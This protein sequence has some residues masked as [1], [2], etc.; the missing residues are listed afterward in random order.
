MYG[1]TFSQQEPPG[2]QGPMP[3][4]IL[5]LAKLHAFY[6][7]LSLVPVFF[8]QLF[9]DTGPPVGRKPSRFCRQLQ[10]VELQGLVLL[11]GVLYRSIA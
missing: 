4:P 2:S 5:L 1:G 6:R 10:L 9:P 7:A 11:V 8:K 3:S